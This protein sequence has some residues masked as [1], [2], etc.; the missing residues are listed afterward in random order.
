MSDINTHDYLRHLYSEQHAQDLERARRALF[1]SDVGAMVASISA[2]TLFD[3]F[4]TASSTY[5]G[6][7]QGARLIKRKRLD[8]DEH[9]KII[10]RR[11]F[12]R[13]YRMDKTSFYKLL[14]ILE[15]YL[16]Q[17]G[18]DR[19]RPGSVRN[20]PITKTSRLAMALRYCAGGDPVDI[21]DHHGVKS[22]EVVRSVWAVVD[23]IH[24]APQMKIEFPRSHQEQYRVAQGFRAKSDIN[25]DVCVGD[26]D[27]ILIWIH[28]PSKSDIKAIKFGPAKFFCGRKKKFGLNMQAVCDADKRFL[29][30]E[31]KFPGSTSDFFAFEQS[32]IKA[33]I[34][35]EGFLRPG[36]CLF[37]DNAYVNAPYMCVPFRNV[38]A[39]TD[40]DAFNF[41]QS[42][43]RIN[44]ECAFGILVHRFGILRKPIPNNINVQKTCSLVL[45]LCKLHNFCIDQSDRSIDAALSRDVAHIVR[46][47][48]EYC[49]RIDE[50]GAAVWEY[51][52]EEDR[53]NA[54]LDGGEHRNDH[55]ATARRRYRWVEDLPRSRLHRVVSAR[56]LT[57]PTRSSYG[58]R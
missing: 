40:K 11:L 6:G 39:G 35:E 43:V 36:Y 56:G 52:E 41:F 3:T 19:S 33:M 44:I 8:V 14:D 16:P 27:G 54:L 26:I 58:N 5:R 21:G 55:S 4:G 51:D 1:L 18:A 53:L 13:K 9:F 57:R 47:G 42:Q 46:E 28:R 31:I 50:D 22:D 38:E 49:P 25:I 17:S 48:G 24:S 29:D 45:A 2:F 12:R 10:G 23:A 15:P 20:G 37:G 7:T 30:V 34:E 32:N